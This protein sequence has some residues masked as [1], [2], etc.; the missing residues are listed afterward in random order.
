MDDIDEN[1]QIILA[2]WQTCVEMANSVSQRRDTINGFFMSF[3]LALITAL[4][5]TWNSMSMFFMI[6]SIVICFVWFLTIRN[7][8][9]LNASKYTVIL[10]LEKKLPYQPFGSEWK[11]LKKN[12]KYKECT[13]L[14]NF[15]PIGFIIFYITVFVYILIN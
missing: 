14:E 1:S 11:E 6:L 13:S 8:R 3:N 2:Q 5:A 4:F 15:I 9:V 7:Y 10:D 12:R